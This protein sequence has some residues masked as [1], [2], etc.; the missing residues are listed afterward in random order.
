VRTPLVRKVKRKKKNKRLAA[1]TNGIYPK[2]EAH[3]GI[4]P[5]QIERVQ[6]FEVWKKTVVKSEMITNIK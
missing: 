6:D 1:A 5:V 2:L 3:G 4:V